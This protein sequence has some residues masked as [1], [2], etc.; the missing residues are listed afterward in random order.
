MPLKPPV[1]GKSRLRGALGHAANAERHAALVLALASDTLLAATEAAGVRRVLVVGS[2]P[3]PLAELRALGVEVVGED[4]PAAGGEGN[5]RGNPADTGLNAALRLGERLLR[6]DDPGGIV[7]ALQAD[8]PALRAS[9]L[10]AAIEEADGRRAFTA[11]RHGT[12]TTLLLSSNG[13][14]LDPRFGAGSAASHE[15]S[16]ATPLGLAAPSLRGDVDT[17]ADL[18]HARLIGLGKRTTAVL[19][20]AYLSR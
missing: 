14:A 12:G 17:A 16:G 2:D 15:R 9:E 11:D 1:A 4:E 18:E 5:V 8:L 13:G 10:S 3:K 20:A 6:A 19:E 7:G